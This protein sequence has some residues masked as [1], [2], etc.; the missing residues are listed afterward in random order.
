GNGITVARSLYR[1]MLRLDPES[2]RSRSRSARALKLV[3]PERRELRLGPLV[4][5]ATFPYSSHN[6]E[7]RWWLAAGGVDPD[8]D[9]RIV[10]LPPTRM[11]A[12]L[13]SGEVHGYCVGEP[14]NSMAA[15]GGFGTI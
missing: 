7:L 9:V 5:A 15:L 13:L 10:A 1:A 4:F 6:Y 14:W 12:M 2:V 3:I 11:A 8:R